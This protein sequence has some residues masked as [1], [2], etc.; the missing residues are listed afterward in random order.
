MS[1]LKGLYILSE[2][3]FRMI[4]PDNMREAI[5]EY[6]EI[7]APPQ[8]R[9]SIRQNMGLLASAEA[10]FSGWGAP[11]FDEPFLDAAPKLEAIFYGAGSVGYC[12]TPRVWERG[13]AVTSANAANAVPVAEYTLANI[14]L[15]LKQAWRFSRQMREDR[16]LPDRNL[17]P[18]CYKSVVGLISM[19]SI[20]RALCRMLAVCELRVVAYDPFL[21]NAEA[22][23]LGIHRVSLD[24]LFSRSDVVSLHTPLFPETRGMITRTH[25]SAMKKNATFINTARAEVVRQDELIEVAKSRPDLQFVLDV[26]APEPL[27]PHSPLLSLQ[28]V[29]LTPHIAGSVGHECSRMGQY[30]VEEL[31]R[32]V[33]GQPLQWAVTPESA[34]NSTHRS[35]H[36]PAS[37]PRA[38]EVALTKLHSASARATEALGS[39][40][41]F[42]TD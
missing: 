16:H 10:I 37:K 33:L 22:Q 41:Q 6:V 27:E 38:V 19:G 4:Y 31:R 8:T 17:A 39:G 1:R 5:N 40:V 18:G 12:M 42:P 7:I 9:D 28:N 2:D 35:L 13:I 21:T 29:L 32:Y 36:R 11:L 30:M 20:A 15:A 25:L 26:T 34:A 3:A 24:E 23:K 14:L